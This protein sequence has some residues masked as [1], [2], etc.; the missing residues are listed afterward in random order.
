MFFFIAGKNRPSLYVSIRNPECLFV[1]EGPHVKYCIA[2]ILHILVLLNSYCSKDDKESSKFM[3]RNLI[4][5]AVN[6]V[7]SIHDDR[8]TYVKS[9]KEGILAFWPSSGG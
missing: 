7:I 4:D 8:H 3:S 6:G 2:H 9:T 5:H 1:A